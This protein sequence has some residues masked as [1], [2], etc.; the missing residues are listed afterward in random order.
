LEAVNFNSKADLKD[1]HGNSYYYWSDGTIR[2]MAENSPHA[3]NSSVLVRDYKYE[4]DLRD[5]NLDGAGRYSETS[6]AIPFNIGVDYILHD[7]V[8]MRL[9]TSIHYNFS[10]NIDNISSKGKGVRKGTGG[11]DAY[12]FSYVTFLFDIFSSEKIV[13]YDQFVANNPNM[14]DFDKIYY[15]D[16]DKDGVNDFD[17]AC[18]G[19][20]LGVA[21]DKKGCP[22]DCD[23]DGIPDYLEK[24]FNTPKGVVV[25]LDGTQYTDSMLQ[26]LAND[27]AK[28]GV[29]YDM[30]EKYY[31][32]LFTSV[33]S[34]ESFSMEIPPKYKYLDVNEDNYISLEEFF[35]EIDR[36]FDG[37][38][39]FSMDEIYE[40]MDF[41]FTQEQ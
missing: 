22:I 31:P 27:T 20:P 26:Q 41:F 36:F 21:V 33:K 1:A 16:E 13:N 38:S 11:N 12:V 15:A 28:A 4:T 5:L 40:L 14:S 2:N 9:G 34:F 24:E 37:K 18:I 30:I 10:D 35:N 32:S 3:A 23:G 39:K 17:D 19:T 7:R 6:I 29:D 8:T 25:D